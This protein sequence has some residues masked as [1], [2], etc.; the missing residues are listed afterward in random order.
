MSTSVSQ[1][2]ITWTFDTDYPTGQFANGD[3][4]VVAPGGLTITGITPGSYYVGDWVSNG[5]MVNPVAGAGAKQGFDNK[6]GPTGAAYLASLNAGRPGGNDLS[7]ANPL[8]LLAG[9]SLV[10]SISLPTPSNRPQLSD[11]A[12]LTVLASAP[13]ELSLRPPYNGTDKKLIPVSA[14]NTAILSS[15][16]DIP[17]SPSLTT[18]ENLVKRVHIEVDTDLGGRNIHPIN[19]Q[20]D[21][22]QFTAYDYEKV[23]MLL[24]LEKYTLEQRTNLFRLMVQKGLDIYGAA[25]S[26]GRWKNN[27]GHNV[28]RKAP[29]VLAA[30]ATG[31]SDLEW[32]ADYANFKKFHEDESIF[33]ITEAEVTR[34]SAGT[35]YTP[36]SVSTS[37][38]R[39]YLTFASHGIPAGGDAK[40]TVVRLDGFTPA[41]Y[42]GH[43]I[44]D[45]DNVTATVVA[46][47]ELNQAYAKNAPTDPVTVMGTVTR[48]TNWKPDNR[49]RVGPYTEGMI[50][51]AEWGITHTGEPESMNALWEALYR[52][53]Y[54]SGL[55]GSTLSVRLLPGGT[56]LWNN[57]AFFNYMDR[58]MV[59]EGPKSKASTNYVYPFTNNFWNAYRN[60]TP[61]NSPPPDPTGLTVAGVGFTN[62]VLE[63][64]PNGAGAVEYEIHSSPT[65]GGLNYTLADSFVAPAGA[66]TLTRT[67]L[68]VP[69]GR[70]RFFRLRAKNSIGNSAWT[71]EVSATPTRLGAPAP[72]R[73]PRLCGPRL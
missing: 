27:G 72:T 13:S 48:I 25:K 52:T 30:L 66:S 54:G 60:Y 44:V 39:I 2:G 18:A 63:W 65:G 17:S 53:I 12:V 67:V 26:G 55:P 19:N 36:T 40:A 5:S 21:Y 32:Y 73:R 34:T 6:P 51:T 20:R 69:S 50:G 7:P 68:G 33:T 11:A 9:S 43:W 41:E 62:V 70:L 3:Y 45:N 57:P 31:D 22:G 23:M 1:Y 38:K 35:V 46:V 15:L 37:G 28:G 10:T 61:P 49:T 47:W 16:P 24:H 58:Y 56:T 59:I 42:N 14:L 8:V 29:L 71:G 64:T 4:Y